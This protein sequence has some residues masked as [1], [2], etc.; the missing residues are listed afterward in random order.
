MR[1]K[2]ASIAPHSRHREARSAAAIQRRPAGLP[3]PSRALNDYGGRFGSGLAQ[4]LLEERLGATV[5]QPRRL[6]AASFAH[7]RREAVILAGIIVDRHPR[8]VVQ[9]LVDCL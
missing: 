3:R 8:M 9:P 5:R 7:L 4:M 2:P 6:L 1:G